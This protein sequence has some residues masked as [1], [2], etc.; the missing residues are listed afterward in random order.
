MAVS[1]RAEYL[2]HIKDLEGIFAELDGVVDVSISGYDVPF[3]VAVAEGLGT[4]PIV[5]LDA[6][7]YTF[8]ATFR[9]NANYASVSTEPTTFEVLNL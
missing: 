3:I 6:G 4:L 9:G 1:E 2:G 8:N 7:T 5:G